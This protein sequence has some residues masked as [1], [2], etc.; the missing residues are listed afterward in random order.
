MK[1]LSA[2]WVLECFQVDDV[3]LACFKW[4]EV[5]SEIEATEVIDVGDGCYVTLRMSSLIRSVITEPVKCREI[6]QGG[7]V[8]IPI[9]FSPAYVQPLSPKYAEKKTNRDI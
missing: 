3:S 6:C 7:R 9:S 4:L 2:L 5:G 1:F 8:L